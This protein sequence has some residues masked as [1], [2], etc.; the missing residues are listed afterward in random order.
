MIFYLIEC[1]C[2]VH[3]PNIFLSLPY[4]GYT[5]S[6]SKRWDYCDVPSCPACEAGD[7][8]QCGCSEVKQADYTGT[9]STTIS[10]EECQAWSSQSPHRH[11]WSGLDSNFCRNPDDDSRGKCN[12]N[13]FLV[14]V[15]SHILTCFFFLC[16]PSLVFSLRTL[17]SA[18]SIVSF[19]LVV[20]EI[21]G[22]RCTCYTAVAR[23]NYQ[24]ILEAV[25]N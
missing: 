11:R 10:G 4:I 21:Q 5:S 1:L 12:F 18:G 20:S 25:M 9:I 15:V 2:V 14:G 7:P 23:I 17:T 3:K 13:I 24:S 8:D 6:G 19:Q 22:Q 16:Y